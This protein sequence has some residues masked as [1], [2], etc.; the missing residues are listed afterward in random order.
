MNAKQHIE[1][2]GRSITLGNLDKVLYPKGGFM[3]AQV[4]GSRKQ[5]L[6]TRKKYLD[7]NVLPNLS[8][9]IRASPVLPCTA[10]TEQGL[11]GLVAKRCD[12]RY[13]SGERSG[14]WMKMR[15]NE[16]QEFVIGGKIFDALV[17][18]YY[19]GGKLLYVARTR[20]GF[21]PSLRD[22][23][24]RKFRGLAHKGV[25]LRQFTGG[26]QRSVG[27]GLDG[28]Q[29][30]GLPMAQA[31]PGRPVEF[32]EWMPDTRVSSHCARKNR[33]KK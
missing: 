19:E 11:E 1:V 32:R 21:T 14:A 7:E 22:S 2:E 28:R 6:E 13:E 5:P 15:V 29:N 24:M 27:T 31:R 10:V 9:P 18:G 25:S 16:G 4:I 8:E 23:L 26:P 33:R 30:E 20:N 3:K 12:S 17:F